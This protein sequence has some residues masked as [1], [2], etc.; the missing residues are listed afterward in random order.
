MLSGELRDQFWANNSIKSPSN[1]H[2]PVR[3]WELKKR[4][5]KGQ[6]STVTPTSSTA[7]QNKS[8]QVLTTK[9]T[10]KTQQSFRN[11]FSATNL[12]RTKNR[13]KDKNFYSRVTIE[14]VVPSSEQKSVQDRT[15][16]SGNDKKWTFY[17]VDYTTRLFEKFYSDLKENDH[18]NNLSDVKNVFL[19]FLAAVKGVRSQTLNR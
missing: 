9:E 14:K 2:S 16:D 13:F 11:S 10:F 1:Y 15:K 19:N 7:S 17:D 3:W 8:D 6:Q 5:K 18:H 12:S 4:R